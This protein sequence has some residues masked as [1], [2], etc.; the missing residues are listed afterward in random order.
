MLA[1]VYDD[2]AIKSR[3][4]SVKTFII[5]CEILCLLYQLCLCL[6]EHLQQSEKKHKNIIT[7]DI[8]SN[9]CFVEA[10]ALYP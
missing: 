2:E 9:N 7:C 4:K 8:M 5:Y 1:G 3:K 6:F 10:F